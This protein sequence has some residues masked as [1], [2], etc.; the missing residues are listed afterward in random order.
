MA[1]S[2]NQRLR[3]SAAKAAK[4]KAEVAVKLERDRRERAISKPRHI[5][6]ATSPLV[7]CQMTQDFEQIGKGTL[8]VARKLTLGRYGASFFLLDLWC[9]GV[10]DAFFRVLDAEE[11]EFYLENAKEAAPSSPMAPEVARK[12]LRDTAAYGTNNG[13]APPDDFAEMERIFGDVAPAEATFTFGVNGRPYYLVGPDDPPA[14]VR[15]IMDQLEWTLGP[16]G[17][18]YEYPLEEDEEAHGIIEG[19]LADDEPEASDNRTGGE[20]GMA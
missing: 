4:R 7:A 9:L 14:R 17:F 18:D 5:D 10:K 16:D 11:Y 12:L 3:K 15:R 20:T 19:E 8:I 6:L 2:Q 13:F 1:V